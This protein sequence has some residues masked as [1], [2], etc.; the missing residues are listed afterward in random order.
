MDHLFVVPSLKREPLLT[1]EM[2]RMFKNQKRIKFFFTTHHGDDWHSLELSYDVY[3]DVI[4]PPTPGSHD[5][6]NLDG[7]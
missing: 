3:Q 5:Q 7:I 1:T 4:V 2:D 6:P